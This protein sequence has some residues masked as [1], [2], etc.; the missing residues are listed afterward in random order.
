MIV[1]PTSG[2]PQEWEWNVD[3]A[4]SNLSPARGTLI[5]TKTHDNGGVFSMEFLV[6]P[7]FRPSRVNAPGVIK[8]F[9]TGQRGLP[10]MLVSSLAEIPFVFDAGIPVDPCGENFVP[11]VEGGQ[12]AG[13]EQ[14]CPKECLT[15][16]LSGDGGGFGP[17]PR[18]CQNCPDV[19]CCHFDGECETIKST[20]QNSAEL[21]CTNTCDP[22]DETSCGTYMGDPNQCPVPPNTGDTDGD[23]ILDL[24]ERSHNPMKNCL[25]A[26]ICETKTLPDEPDTDGDGCGD[27]DERDA[28]P[29]TDACD[30]CSR[31]AGW[32]LNPADDCNLND[33]NDACDVKNG[34]DCDSNGVIECGGATKEDYGV[35]CSSNRGCEQ[36]TFAVCEQRINDPNSTYVWNWGGF[37]TDCPAG[38]DPNRHDGYDIVHYAVRPPVCDGAPS[39]RLTAEDCAS[40]D[41]FIDSWITDT[42]A[43]TAQKF[44]IDG[45]P[46]IPADFFGDGSDQFEGIIYLEGVPLGMTEYGEYA[47][48]DTLVMRWEDPF[49]RCVLPTTV[50][51]PVDLKV[52]ALSLAG[53]DSI[54][55]TYNGGQDPEEWDVVVGLSDRHGEDPTPPALMG[56]LTAMK[57]HCNG[58][59]YVSELRIWPKLTFSKVGGIGGNCEDPDDDVVCLDTA[60]EGW[61]V[62]SLQQFDDPPEDPAPLWNHDPEPDL[63]VAFDPCTEFHPVSGEPAPVTECDCQTDGE[64][65]Y[66]V[67][68]KCDIEEGTSQD[69]N[70]S[71]VPDEC[72]LSGNDCNDNDI[73]DDCEDDCNR[74]GEP[75][76]C[77][78]DPT[79]PDGNGQVSPDCN[80]NG[81][82]DECENDCNGNQRVDQCDVP[83][84]VG[85]PEGLCTVDCSEDCNEN[86]TPD[87]CE[88]DCNGNGAPDSCDM[89]RPVDPSP[90]CQPNGRPD[91]CDLASGIS[92]DC[93]D[94]PNGIPDECDIASGTS[95]DRDGD[96]I[97]D[98]CV[99]CLAG[100][101]PEPDTLALAGDPVDLKN[102]YLSIMA[103]DAGRFQAIRVVIG[104]L[105]NVPPPFDIWNGQEYYAGEPIQICENAGQGTNVDPQDPLACGPAPGL[106]QDWGFY[107]P[108]ICD[109]SQAHYM[110][111]TTLRDYCNNPQ[112]PNNAHP[113]TEDADCGGGTCGV[114]GV[115]HLYHEAIVPSHMATSG[116]PIDLPADYDIQVIGSGASLSDQNCYSARLTM[117]Q[118]GWGDVVLN[119][120]TCPNG[121]P[122][123]NVGVVTDVVS[124]LNKFSNNF[125]APTKARTDLVP[126]NT[127]KKITISD[128]VGVLDAFVGGDYAF[129]SGQCVGGLC[130]GGPDH[131]SMCT[132]DEDCSSDPCKF[133]LDVGNAAGIRTGSLP[134]ARTRGGRT[135]NR[136]RIDP[137][138]PTITVIPLRSVIRPGDMLHV[139]VYAS[140][141]GALRAYELKL[142]V[143]GGDDGE[144]SLLDLA[145]DK[146]HP[147]Y[148]FSTLEDVG[149][150]DHSNSRIGGALL[151]GGVD[152]TGQGYLG[153]FTF[154]ASTQGAGAFE[155]SISVDD[156][157]SLLLSTSSVPMAFTAK[158]AVVTVSAGPVGNIAG[159]T[160]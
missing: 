104:G 79:D 111:W 70:E 62:I 11:G 92:K 16:Y 124:L 158:P 17:K 130:S 77:D 25:E 24:Y 138:G 152:V 141:V 109:T 121:V 123:E 20:P 148:V 3:V 71:G 81:V 35:C 28:E 65:G 114:D 47:E 75:D 13:R 85:Y 53:K 105:G 27:G 142:A 14:D 59:E 36:T 22:N 38:G 140:N 98:E 136:E 147:D 116:G 108:L 32:P 10:P 125:C 144:L 46:A 115:V 97:P 64:P 48:A 37:C 84:S 122:E 160:E 94:P 90:D 74:N 8:I 72:E 1:V 31:P 131:G 155:L 78:V 83:P 120:A 145:I 43:Q 132:T 128:V 107:A 50:A 56:S 89:T 110:D 137:P 40:R 129:G 5:A 127:D 143:Q 66:G 61:N 26:H 57:N 12:G 19:T 39:L 103:G 88:P 68:D 82:P 51:D 119:V 86:G 76:D 67:R 69:C 21:I 154:Q 55:V 41:Y 18:G 93:Q 126:H 15:S 49:D 80:S 4:L 95:P 118:A 100:S 101:P 33:V 54:T 87:E 106:P 157:A 63:N 2:D 6:Q 34:L 42:H 7:V 99:P 112:G 29:P 149:A 30:P 60:N 153:T 159:D 9:D 117:T 73:P 113:C 150:V 102:R 52:V 134:S 23:G 45:A 135:V 58:G 133:G 96:G 146:H 151:S 156:R 91:G 139:D 44:G